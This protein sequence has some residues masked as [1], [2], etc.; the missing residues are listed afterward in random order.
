[1]SPLGGSTEVAAKKAYE[2]TLDLAQALNMVADYQAYGGCCD[3]APLYAESINSLQLALEFVAVMGERGE[4][5][6]VVV[7]SV[8]RFT[9]TV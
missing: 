8:C 1:M 9:S 7:E 5:Y 4:A 2:A 3:A 6:V